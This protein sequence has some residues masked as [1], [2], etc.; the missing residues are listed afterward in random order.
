MEE[1]VHKELLELLGDKLQSGKL[2]KLLDQTG[3]KPSL[4]KPIR[5]LIGLAMGKNWQEEAESA[6]NP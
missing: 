4:L 2:K 6:E 3:E 5:S 1:S